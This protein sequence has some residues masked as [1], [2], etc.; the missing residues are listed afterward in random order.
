MSLRLQ[1][2]YLDLGE[3]GI[4]G[5]V[6]YAVPEI[7]EGVVDGLRPPALLLVAPHAAG[8]A[9][10]AAA[11][12]AA[13]A[14]AASPANAAGAAAAAAAALSLLGPQNNLERFLFRFGVTMIRITLLK[15]C[16]RT[17]ISLHKAKQKWKDKKPNC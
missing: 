14:V 2:S 15:M 5:Y 11:T 6:G 13:A 4:T 7:G 1:H 8:R 16:L 17:P 3:L 9:A 10:H 12:A